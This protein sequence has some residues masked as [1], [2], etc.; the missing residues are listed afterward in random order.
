MNQSVLNFVA[1]CIGK[2]DVQGKRIL[3]VGALDFN[4][5]VRKVIS[6]L[7]PAQYIGVDIQAGPGVDEICAAQDLIAK[8][9]EG[10]FDILASTEM[11][12]HVKPWRVILH[13]LKT[14]V[15]PNGLLLV[16][17]RSK[18]FF[19]HGYPHDYWRYEIEDMQKLF[20]DC[21]IEKLEKDP[22]SPGVMIKAR[23][24]VN[25]VEVD[26]NDWKLYSILHRKRVRST[27]LLVEFSM[28]GY[29]G[30]RQ[31]AR[32]LLRG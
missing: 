25:F 23:K 16:T 28:R 11:M 19:Y 2:E 3:E 21:V 5:S 1:Q 20:S 4:G 17:T 32:K 29:Y 30:A 10:A 7:Q 6:P 9:G 26:L 13:N 15:R 22:R 18:G 24:P 8:F 31:L 12:E 14:V 27:N